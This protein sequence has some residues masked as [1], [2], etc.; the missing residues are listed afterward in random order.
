M[1]EIDGDRFARIEPGVA[2]PP[3]GSERLAGL[4]L[5]GFANA[6]SH[7]FHRALRGRTQRGGGSF[8]TWREDMYELAARLDPDTYAALARATFAEMA[9]AGIT[10]VGEFHYLHHA[11]GGVPYDDPNEIGRALVAAAGEAGIRI[12]LLDACYLRG[13]F[14]REL[15]REQ[16]RFGDPGA[17]GWV[18]RVEALG[19]LGP[20]AR[21][22][23]GGPQRP[24]GRP[25]STR[26]GRRLGR[27]ARVA[28]ARARLRAAGRERGLRR[29][30][31]APPR[32]GARRRRRALASASPPSTSPTSRTRTSACSASTRHLLPVPDDRARPRRRRRRG[33]RSPTPARGWRSARIRTRSSTSS[34]R[35][36]RSSSTSGW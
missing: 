33:G 13:G 18:E 8:W 17:A 11:P 29:R 19:D 20:G 2:T 4:T 15:E 6:H 25:R 28:A 9:L 12:T 34:R 22:G 27:A 35:C 3:P 31:R 30:P 1:V 32:G 16:L 14:D 24:R 10:A 26:S 7:A 21:I 5:P 36:G 23:G